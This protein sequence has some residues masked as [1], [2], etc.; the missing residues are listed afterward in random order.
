MSSCAG[1]QL[2]GF[3]VS[4]ECLMGDDKVNFDYWLPPCQF[5]WPDAHDVARS[6]LVFAWKFF[7]VLCCRVCYCCVCMCYGCGCGYAMC[8]QQ[9][10]MEGW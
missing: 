6:L 10:T 9:Q 5:G 2:V 4:S 1:L 3:V 8:D 7:D